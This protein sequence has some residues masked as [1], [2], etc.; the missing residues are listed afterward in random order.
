MLADS[1]TNH[2]THLPFNDCA[3]RPAM[4]TTKSRNTALL[5]ALVLALGILLVLAWLN[6]SAWFSPLALLPILAMLLWPATVKAQP[7]ATAAGSTDTATRLARE[8]S[9]S[10]SQNALTAAGVSHAA[11]QLSNKLDSLVAAAT[12]IESSAEQMIVTEEQTARLSESGLDSASEVRANSEAGLNGLS[13]TIA[14]IQRLSEQATSNS[15]LVHSLSQRSEEIQQVT[16]VIQNIASQTNLLALNAAI[17][18]ARA[19]EAGRGFAVVADEVRGLASRTATATEEVETMVNDIRLHTSEVASQ[20]QQLMMELTDSV[21]LVEH[22]GEQLSTITRLA[23]TVE[24]QMG[25]ITGGTQSNRLRLDELFHAVAR[26]R[27]DLSVSDTQ[28]QQLSKAASALESQTENISERL[29]EVSLSDYH[30]AVYELARNAAQAIGE[31]FSNDITKGTIRESDLFNRNL[32]PIGNTTPQKYNSSFDRYTDNVLP[33]IQE[34]I[35]QHP[36]VVFAISCTPEGY[37]PTHNLPYSQPLTGNAEQDYL[38]NRTKRL[39]NDKVGSRCGSH[40]KPML[41]Q[42]YIRETGEHMHDLSVPIHVNGK[43]WG[44]FRIGYRPEH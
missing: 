38:N 29:S 32:T 9:H 6:V 8:L 37:I 23:I 22:A 31:R 18:A 12:H 41:L 10:T 25:Q 4:T 42:T 26:M 17:E 35:L 34:P 40:E 28:T 14:C 11:A 2:D 16:A 44:G 33:E 7:A 21:G 19:G 15:E 27:Q 13:Q 39:F 43:H 5:S 1:R 20:L 24:D 3:D 30:Q 36:G